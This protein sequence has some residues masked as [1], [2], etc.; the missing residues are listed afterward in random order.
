MIIVQLDSEQL[1]GLI[2][3]A[4]R[5]VI[6]EIPTQPAQPEPET[7]LTVE[8][9]ANFLHLSVPTVYTKIS[10]GELPVIKNKGS[11]RCYFSKSDL[12]EYLKTGRRKTVQEN[13]ILAE[14]YLNKKAA[15]SFQ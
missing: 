4:V 8:E 15:T 3:T 5:K 1:S 12:F 11:K 13:A 14:K 2:Q 9:A 6:A 10:K 7:L